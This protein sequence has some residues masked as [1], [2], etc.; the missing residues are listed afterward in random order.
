MTDQTAVADYRCGFVAIAGRANVGKST[1]LNRLVDESVSIVTHKPQTTRHRING[2]LSLDTAQLVFVDT[3]GL[4]QRSGLAL[5]RSMNKAVY[6]AVAD[7]DVVLFMVSAGRWQQTDQQVLELLKKSSTPVLLVVNQVDRMT[8]REQLL[9]WLDE[10]ARDPF[11]QQVLL[12]SAL[13]GDGIDELLRLL[14]AY[15]PVSP[16][17]YPTDQ[18]SDRSVR[19]LCAELVREQLLRRMH[20]ELPYGMHVEIEEFDES[21]KPITIGAVIWVDRE[22]HK[23]MVIGNGG[24]KMKQIGRASRQRIEK[25]IDAHVHLRLW[26][27]VQEGWTDNVNMLQ[28]SGL[29]SE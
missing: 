24:V 29:F 22:S 7:A 26:V 9:P 11:Y 8:D 27:R 16:P 18:L 25:L 12:I 5:N 17:L 10:H 28:K 14:P 6:Q 19:F 1:L 23:G 2:I 20:K 21:T 4:Q 15:L 3:P 13:R